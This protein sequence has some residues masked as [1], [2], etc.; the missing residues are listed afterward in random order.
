M[1]QLKAVETVVPTLS[2]MPEVKFQLCCFVTVGPWT[3]SLGSLDI[4]LL[5]FKMHITAILSIYSC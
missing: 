3:G 1:L 4:A 5:C 2:R